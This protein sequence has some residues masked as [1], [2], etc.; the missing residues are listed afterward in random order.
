MQQPARGRRPDLGRPILDVGGLDV[1]GPER[2]GPVRRQHLVVDR[3]PLLS[4]SADGAIDLLRLAL[5]KACS[6]RPT[7]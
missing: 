5:C 7:G 4:M 3:L 1:S 2:I 6:D